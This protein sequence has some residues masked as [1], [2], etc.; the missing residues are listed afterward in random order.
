MMFQGVVVV[1]DILR[2]KSILRDES[3]SAPN[4]LDA[5]HKL[6][7]RV[8]PRNVLKS[9]KIGELCHCFSSESRGR[10]VP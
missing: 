10:V 1:D 7:E 6:G 9:T 8:P 4:L 3:Q 2:L 5:L